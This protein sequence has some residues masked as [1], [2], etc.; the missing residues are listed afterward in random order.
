MVVLW[1][2]L[3]FLHQGYSLVPVKTVK[4]GEAATLTCAL[5]EEFINRVHWYKQSVG[6]TLKF[7]VTLYGTTSPQF[8]SEFNKLRFGAQIDA[9]FSSLTILKTVHEDEGIY[10]CGTD[11]WI[12]IKWNGTYL[13]IKGNTQRTSNYTVVQ[14]PVESNP[15]RPGDTADLQ[16]SVFSD[17]EN[18]TCPGGHNVFWFRAG[19]HPNIIYTDGNSTNQCE[20]RSETQKKCVYRI[21]KNISSSDN[22]TYYCAVAT[23]GEILFGNGTTLEVDQTTKLIFIQMAILIS[24]LAVSVIGN[25]FFIWNRSACK[26]CKGIETAISEVQTENLHPPVDFLG[27]LGR[28][29]WCGST[30]PHLLVVDSSGLKDKKSRLMQPVPSLPARSPPIKPA[31]YSF[32]AQFFYVS[33]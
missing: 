15:V 11:N 2:L 3:L 13:L 24:C 6:D 5:P 7:I 20:K 9:N 10:H 23:C 12:N 26:K 30:P 25:V 32:Q 19:S 8:A 31:Q 17:S 28:D 1:I 18:E 4:L 27:L 21:S 14:Q 33:K 16:C 29:V 22:G